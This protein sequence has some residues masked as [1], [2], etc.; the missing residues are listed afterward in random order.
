MV[1]D[2]L[3]FQNRKGEISRHKQSISLN[4]D[5]LSWRLAKDLAVGTVISTLQ[6]YPLTSYLDIFLPYRWYHNIRFKVTLVL[7]FLK[8]A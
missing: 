6:S 7:P 2:Q 8:M 1:C 3:W 5:L 4:C